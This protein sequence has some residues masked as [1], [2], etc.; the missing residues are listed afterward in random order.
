M[1]SAAASC[2]TLDTVHESI[3]EL[4]ELLVLSENAMRADLTIRCWG[5]RKGIKASA[6][7]KHVMTC[8]R[9]PRHIRER[10]VEARRAFEKAPEKA[11]LVAVRAVDHA[12][13]Q[14]ESSMSD[15]RC[16]MCGTIFYKRVVVC[17]HKCGA[18]KASIHVM[19][20][21]ELI[22]MGRVQLTQ[23]GFTEI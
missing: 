16:L 21:D 10:F 15:S 2:V 8:Q 19:P 6:L 17:C 5:C 11:H 23:D 14:L 9:I 7:S 12:E 18:G 13:L 20:P 22:F 3:H 1:S 4:L